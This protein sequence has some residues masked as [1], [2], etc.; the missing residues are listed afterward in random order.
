MEIV[1]NIATAF[2]IP[3]VHRWHLLNKWMNG[4]TAEW[5]DV[6]ERTRGGRVLLCYQNRQLSR[7][8]TLVRMIWIECRQSEGDSTNKRA[9]HAVFNPERPQNQVQHVRYV[10]SLRFI[11]L[12]LHWTLP[13]WFTHLSMARLRKEKK[14][15]KRKEGASLVL[16]LSNGRAFAIVIVDVCL[17]SGGCFVLI[18]VAN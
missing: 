17:L 1:P 8:T 10:G 9:W 18:Q 14:K 4:L 13:L 12:I 15:R 3:S 11:L 16:P 6:E 7:L 2:L 5:M